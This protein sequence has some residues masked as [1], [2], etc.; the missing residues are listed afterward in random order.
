MNALPDHFCMIFKSTP[1]PVPGPLAN[2]LSRRFSARVVVFV[3]GLMVGTG[4]VLNAFATSTEYM[5]FT[6]TLI[7]G[8]IVFIFKL[9]F[10][11]RVSM[12]GGR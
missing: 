11:D 9:F 8:K 4:S 6:Y 1:F 10:C 5:I 3:G 2:A 7:V 12:C